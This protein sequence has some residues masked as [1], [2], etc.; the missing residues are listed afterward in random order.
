MDPLAYCRD[1]AAPDG[2]A[3]YY[4]V[5][6][7]PP[8]G[9]D[10]LIAL[11]ALEQELRDV[12]EA[13]SEL[14][15]AN[16]KLAFWHGEIMRLLDGAP[17][18]PVTLALARCAADSLDAGVLKALVDG[19]RTR[20][21]SRQVRDEEELD[22]AC[23]ATAGTMARVMAGVLAPGDSAA[24]Q[25]LHT[26]A[27]AL[28]RLRLLRFP[29]RAGLPPHSGVPLQLLTRCGVTPTAMDRGGDDE[30]LVKLRR[31]L[32]QQASHRLDAASRSLASRRGLA[33]TR[34]RIAQ[35]QAMTL[36]RGGYVA[37]GVAR[38]LL[39][40]VLLWCAWRTRPGRDA[41]A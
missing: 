35:A 25:A 39:P 5:L 6:F 24:A 31:E 34:V 38:E 28:E 27:T 26:T 20:L 13:C 30:S 2:S 15:V 41:R 1:K 21:N 11:L 16:H 9:R 12:V 3:D 29:R 33:A 10:A 4:A 14:A 7:Q 18:H 32:L 40:I 36:K 22:A 19:V 23:A 8:P 37:H 17:E